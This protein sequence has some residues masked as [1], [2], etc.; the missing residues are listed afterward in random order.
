MSGQLALS[1][2]DYLKKHCNELPDDFKIAYTGNQYKN[3]PALSDLFKVNKDCP[4]LNDTIKETYH[5][6]TA[7]TL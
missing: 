1:Q 6:I 2:Y 7:K 4:L 5:G 3:S